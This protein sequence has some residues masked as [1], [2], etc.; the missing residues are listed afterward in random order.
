MSIPTCLVV[1]VLSNLL[2]G[3]SQ[4][5]KA[6]SAAKHRQDELEANKKMAEEVR[7]DGGGMRSVCG[8]EGKGRGRQGGGGC[9]AEGRRGET[10]G[11][12]A[13]LPALPSRVQ[14]EGYGRMLSVLSVA[15]YPSPWQ[16]RNNVCP[17]LSAPLP[18]SHCSRGEGGTGGTPPALPSHQPPR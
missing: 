2:L 17:P 12:K 1:V 3:R 11:K 14:G 16:R 7:G 15:L 8:G 18:R 6:M 5:A 9:C 10:Y 4:F 13:E